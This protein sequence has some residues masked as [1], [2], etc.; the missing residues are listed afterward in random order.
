MEAN[1]P[2]HQQNT[3]TMVALAVAAAVEQGQG[4]AWWIL[5]GTPG[6]GRKEHKVPPPRR[7]RQTKAAN[8]AHARGGR[9]SPQGTREEQR[10]RDGTWPSLVAQAI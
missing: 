3:Q 4:P 2:N 5:V 9:D 8:A 10:E 6:A 1:L 7:K